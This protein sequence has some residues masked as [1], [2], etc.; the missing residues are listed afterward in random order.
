MRS[1]LAS[2]GIVSPS[3]A[4]AVTKGK[5][6]P[7]GYLRGSTLLPRS[8]HDYLVIEDSPAGI[9]AGR[10]SDCQVIAVASSHNIQ[11]LWRA[12]WIVASLDQIQLSISDTQSVLPGA[13]PRALIVHAS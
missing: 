2:V 10:S 5:P 9:Q 3:S 1:R 8:P 11:D 12:D 7:E 4:D 6:S 13:Y